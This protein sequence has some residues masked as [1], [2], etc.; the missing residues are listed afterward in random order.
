VYCFFQLVPALDLLSMV[1]G[2]LVAYFFHNFQLLFS[3]KAV[4]ESDEW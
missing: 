4:L 1:S 3:A 2:K